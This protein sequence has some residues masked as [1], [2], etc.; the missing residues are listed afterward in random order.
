MLLVEHEIQYPM[1][2][3]IPNFHLQPFMLHVE[4]QQRMINDIQKPGNHD[5]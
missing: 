2:W 1:G 3:L 5:I 4:M